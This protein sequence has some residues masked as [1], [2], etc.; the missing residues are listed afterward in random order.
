M[1]ASRTI[2]VIGA[3]T[4]ASSYA[5]AQ[6]QTQSKDLSSMGLEELMKV[7]VTTESKEAQDLSKVPAAVYVITAD[8]IRRSGATSIPEL[9][10]VVPGVQVQQ[11]SPSQWSVGIRGMGDRF[12][13]K[14]LVLVDGRTVYSPS[15]SG[16][17]WDAQDIDVSLIERIEVIRGPGGTLW[18][19]NAVNGII[20]II[21]KSAAKTKGNTLSLES[22]TLAPYQ[23]SFVHGGDM[24]NGSY[25]VNAQ[26]F[27]QS[28]L[29]TIAG[30]SGD[31]G[32]DDMNGGFRTDW[33]LGGNSYTLSG[34]ATSSHQGS[35]LLY[36][37]LGP[38]YAAL[39]YD[40]FMT[41]EYSL[42]G[43]WERTE[44]A[45]KGDS[46]QISFDHYDRDMPEA[47]DRR[48]TGSLD[49]QHGVHV[50]ASN[51]MIVGAGYQ[52]TQGSDYSTSHFTI[53]P[54][55]VTNQL[56]SAF[57]MDEQNIGRFLKA[58]LGAK[59]EHNDYTGWEFQPTLRLA[60]T[61]SPKQ[62]FWG[63]ISR[64][65]RTPAIAEADA[66]TFLAG[67][68]GPGGLPVE[69]LLANNPNYQSEVLV[70]DE[71]GW[72]F[73]PSDRSYIDI[74][75]F[76]NQYTGLRGGTLVG[77]TLNTTPFPYAVETFQQA[78]DWSAVPA[79]AELAGHYSVSHSWGLDASYAFYT[80]SYST[81]VASA[82]T[83]GSAAAGANSAPMHQATLQSHLNLPGAMEFDS[84]LYYVGAL[85]S[86]PASV[87][88][89]ARLDLRLAWHANK[90]TD[91]SV[92]VTNLT[93]TNHLEA[94]DSVFVESSYIPRSAYAKVV[95]HF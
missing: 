17:Y 32:W 86:Y 88:A 13:N 3:L 36:P 76:Y 71:L 57:A 64:A 2:F 59:F 24:P 31:N 72:R 23:V 61:P 74:A 50:S 35:Q 78:N 65:V 63:A 55:T 43:K 9:L 37:V 22:S 62:T 54:A 45:N 53:E 1:K 75:T 29:N 28:D 4:G 56:Y 77:Q 92:G 46:L 41:S 73:T 39:A 83:L 82:Y 84:T 6:A 58:S 91:F 70:A 33:G 12:S 7:Q 80:E 79:G 94:Y 15:F 11:I 49:Y 40:R 14:L 18:G 87:P 60:Y 16:V 81:T 42:T 44:G 90:A 19:T 30:N 5:L 10:R 21:T 67:K 38:P 93:N 95:Y 52:V 48:T 68:P 66:S 34:H 47:G 8:Q 85:N 20:N 26:A 27:R 89:Y 25:R 69:V 51:H